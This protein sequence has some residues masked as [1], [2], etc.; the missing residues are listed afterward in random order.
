MAKPKKIDSRPSAEGRRAEKSLQDA[1]RKVL[2]ENRRL[3]IP[4][5]VMH[6]GKAVWMPVEKALE[7]ERKKAK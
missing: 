5:A 2:E 7:L 4:I 6:K 1:V 3:G